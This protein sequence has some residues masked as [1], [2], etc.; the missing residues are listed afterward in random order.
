MQHL[1]YTKKEQHCETCLACT[2]CGL[3]SMGVP[4]AA[5]AAQGSLVD[6]GFVYF[7]AILEL[8]YAVFSLFRFIHS[9]E[10]QATL[11]TDAPWVINKWYF[12]AHAMTYNWCFHI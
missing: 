5:V 8:H 1:I 9:Y 3:P 4:D 2:G 12:D 11:N 6:C 10:C 7:C